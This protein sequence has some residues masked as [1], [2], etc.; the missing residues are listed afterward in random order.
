MQTWDEDWGRICE[1]CSVIL[2]RHNWTTND[3]DEDERLCDNC[4][5]ETDKRFRAARERLLKSDAHQR[6]L[7]RL[8]DHDAD[9]DE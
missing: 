1:R 3:D 4:K 2:S 7:N 8:A 9:E 5:R 6:L